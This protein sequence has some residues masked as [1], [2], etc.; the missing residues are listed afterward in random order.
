MI[1]DIQDSRRVD[2]VIR[3]NQKLDPSPQEIAAARQNAEM[4]KQEDTSPEGMVKP[5][6]HAKI[7][8]R[9]FWPQLHSEDYRVP[10]DIAQLQKS[11]EQ[12][13]ESLKNSRKLTWLQGLRSSYGR[14]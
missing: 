14:A 12:G 11:Y 2:G 10:D 3:R 9:L 1:K 7:L 4:F 8:S 5:S 13:F 6:M